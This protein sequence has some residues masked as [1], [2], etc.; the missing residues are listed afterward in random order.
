[1]KLVSSWTLLVLVMMDLGSALAGEGG[2]IGSGGDGRPR[3]AA[4]PVTADVALPVPP[5]AAETYLGMTA[6]WGDDPSQ[7]YSNFGFRRCTRRNGQVEF[8]SCEAWT[9]GYVNRN[10]VRVRPGFYQV[11]F[12]NS[13]Y[14]AEIVRGER[15]VIRLQAILISSTQEVRVFR[16]LSQPSERTKVVNEVVGRPLWNRSEQPEFFGF[17]RTWGWPEGWEVASSLRTVCHFEEYSESLRGVLAECGNQE[18]LRNLV[19]SLLG[20]GELGAFSGVDPGPRRVFNFGTMVVSRDYRSWLGS[21]FFV[22]S[23]WVGSGSSPQRVWVLPGVYG[24][25][26][27]WVEGD[28][29]SF[30]LGI[31]VEE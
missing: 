24:A 9:H 16:D 11:K 17:W 26:Y 23:S 7:I 13:L 10:P 22:T 31:R 5:A 30:V 28:E 14:E 25:E 20:A 18:S 15:K 27:R 19:V 3:R 21:R 29:S 2:V 6:E 12:A 8:A 1:M 4:P